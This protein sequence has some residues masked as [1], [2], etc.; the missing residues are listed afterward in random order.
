MTPLECL[1]FIIGLVDLFIGV[2]LLAVLIH[3]LNVSRKKAAARKEAIKK[4]KAFIRT[5][6]FAMSTGEDAA[7]RGF[8]EVAPLIDT[9]KLAR[10]D[11]GTTKEELARKAL[12]SFRRYIHNVRQERLYL[13]YRI[14]DSAVKAKSRHLT[15]RIRD[16]HDIYM[17]FKHEIRQL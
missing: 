2:S 14:Q 13:S 10:A 17:I 6:D 4:C 3:R 7:C 16:L 15:R 5:L 8:R 11:I 1:A 12:K 9:Y